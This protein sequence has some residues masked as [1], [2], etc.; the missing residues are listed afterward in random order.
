MKNINRILGVILTLAIL[1]G[2]LVMAVPVSAGTNT[3]TELGSMPGVTAGTDANIFTI[4]ADGTTMYMW[5]PVETNATASG[6]TTVLVNSV[7][8]TFA[9]LTVQSTAGFCGSTSYPVTNLSIPVGIGSTGATIATVTAVIDSKTL[10]FAL[11]GPTF[12]AGTTPQVYATTATAPVAL[13]YKSTDAGKTW[14]AD[15]LLPPDNTT[16]FKTV[17]IAGLKVCPTSSDNLI[18]W[19]KGTGT[20]TGLTGNLYR[21]LNG[22]KTWQSTAVADMVTGAS[23]IYSADII[24]N[25]G[26]EILVGTDKGV[27]L[28]VV[29]NGVWKNT[30]NGTLGTWTTPETAFA[31]AFAPN[32][33][34][35]YEMLA[36]TNNG[37]M[38]SLR[39]YVKN[40]TSWEQSGMKAI[41]KSG[42]TDNITNI[43]GAC[44]AFPSDFDF[45]SAN[46]NKVFV[47]INTVNPATGLS[48]GAGG[49]AYRVAG[50]MVG[51]SSSTPKAYD[52]GLDADV[53]SLDFS[54]TYNNGTLAVGQVATTL[55]Y[56]VTTAI[57]QTSPDADT[58]T[59]NFTWN[60]SIKEPYGTGGYAKV[61][62]AST[63]K[64]YAGT[65]GEFSAF[66]Q[67]N[68]TTT[69]S[70]FN[71]ISMIEV[72]DLATVNFAGSSDHLTATWPNTAAAPPGSGSIAVKAIQFQKTTDGANQLI[73]QSSLGFPSDL[74]DANTTPLF[75]G[76]TIVAPYRES[77]YTYIKRIIKSTDGGNTWVLSSV[78]LPT[79]TGSTT[80][81]L[82][83]L[84]ADAYWIGYSGYIRSNT[85]IP[86]PLLN[87]LTPSTITFTNYPAD[88]KSILVR[89]NEGSFLYTTDGGATWSY[90]GNPAQWPDSNIRYTKYIVNG[91]EK[92]Q[93]VIDSS[94]NIYK[95]ILGTSTNWELT[96]LGSPNLSSTA[97]GTFEPTYVGK[98]SGMV[99]GL[100][101]SM[102]FDIV[103]G[104]Y[105]IYTP[106]NQYG[107][108]WRNADVNGQYWRGVTNSEFPTTTNTGFRGT[109]G[110]GTINV[111]T[112]GTYLYQ[113][114]LTGLSIAPTN[115]STWSKIME[116]TD[117]AVAAPALTSPAKDAEVNLP[118][119]F[120]YQSQYTSD[121]A[122]YDLQIARD[123]K[124]T[125]GVIK[126]TNLYLSQINPFSTSELQTGNKYYW[127]VRL[128]GTT[129]TSATSN[130]TTTYTGSGLMSKWSD[131]RALT[132]K[133]A[134]N[135][136]ISVDDVNSVYPARGQT[137]VAIIPVLTWGTVANATYN[138]Q[139]AT[140]AAF[141]NA[142]DSATALTVAVW[143]PAKALDT[144]K[145]YYWK[146]QAV[147]NGIS[148]DW[149]AFAFTTAAPAPAAGTG[150][151]PAATA[152]PAPAQ[153]I[154]MPTPVINVPA[155][156]VNV[157]VPT[158]GSTQAPAT[159]PYIWVIIVIG[160]VLV[161]AVVVLIVRTRRV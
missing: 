152:A 45:T 122:V 111:S 97:P 36:V 107:Q 114:K 157:N 41:I 15:G 61:K 106:G 103:G 90:L 53:S 121:T 24:D 135:S 79:D 116:F 143:S 72:P 62:F 138:V 44:L 120:S 76:S 137:G 100:N 83:L 2:L 144:S 88:T 51:S 6:T 4:A 132:I 96:D 16:S 95:W 110:T 109:M 70:S 156:T 69:F 99:Y 23:Y 1:A 126:K 18:A 52:L 145:T 78:P 86:I 161:V 48:L 160:A 38:T 149:V 73:L 58:G 50:L 40:E 56:G 13:L 139:L 34:T 46:T 32:Y 91:T 84:S 124:F 105:F 140:D 71:G 10:G 22:G 92:A 17:A 54:G 129:S 27:G 80:S 113:Y 108:L 8:T 43:T 101:T 94:N 31:V 81:A 77:N 67:A 154:V 33:T 150:G 37:S 89:C 57:V 75:S 9:T 119:D 148:S 49:D 127:R 123:D 66:S 11:P 65:K 7:S 55:N 26:L 102:K 146:V 59:N 20:A 98:V 117:Q 82:T 5:S 142:V 39:N 134:G 128:A 87:A 118:V 115:G 29:N 130:G 60:D 12:T 63:G 141:K 93:W 21:S 74:G 133:T 19:E 25:G 104:V 112:D 153:T 151:A 42:G 14:S 64:L 155:A 85:G 136:S 30:V 47:G 125:L 68:D 158:P 28:N 3:W 159:P 147:V 35:T 131:A